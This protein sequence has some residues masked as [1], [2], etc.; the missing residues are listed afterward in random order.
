MTNARKTWWYAIGQNKFW[1][2]SSSEL[3]QL[4]EQGKLFPD[5][6]V[7]KEGMAKWVPASRIK[8]LWQKLPDTPPLPAASSQAPKQAPAQVQFGL[9]DPA[10]Q[11]AQAD[12]T[13]KFDNFAPLQSAWPDEEEYEEEVAQPEPVTFKEAIVRCFKKY[14]VFS[15]RAS[16][17]EYWYF[18]L[19][20][21]G[22]AFLLGFLFGLMN[23]DESSIDRMIGIFQLALFLPHIAV[24]TR[25][26]HD[27]DRSGWWQLIVLTGIGFFVLLYWL[28]KA[29]DE[30]ENEYG[31]PE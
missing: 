15:G 18:I 12:P 19:F 28:I 25:R 10:P 21:Y 3:I 16:R 30:G 14:V 24:T 11:P 8:G 17:A 5:S 23:M 1:P 2:C 20:I 27:I 29:G 6:L 13:A 31:Y 7:W 22:L 4:V 26:L 9:P